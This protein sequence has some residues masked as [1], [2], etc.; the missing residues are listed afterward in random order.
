VDGSVFPLLSPEVHDQL[1]CFVD[2]GERFFS[3]GTAV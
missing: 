3:P 2:M 1:F